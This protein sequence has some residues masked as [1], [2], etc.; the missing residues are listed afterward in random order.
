[1]DTVC[2]DVDIH[3]TA[4]VDIDKWLV[5]T[6]RHILK[7][8]FKL[9]VNTRVVLSFELLGLGLIAHRFSIRYIS[10]IGM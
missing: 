1:M 2:D 3:P 6:L 10:L 5:V 8:H 7:P 9:L 4:A